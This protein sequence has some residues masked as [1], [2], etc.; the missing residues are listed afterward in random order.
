M[1]SGRKGSDMSDLQ[2]IIAIL[3]ILAAWFIGYI[4]GKESE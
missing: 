3:L 4:M 1:S 2:Q